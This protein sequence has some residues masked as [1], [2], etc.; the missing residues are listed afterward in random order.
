MRLAV[1]AASW[2][3][4]GLQ[5]VALALIA[6]GLKSVNK[7]SGLLIQVRQVIWNILSVMC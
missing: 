6:E 1:G 5:L 2:L 3:A 7:S 4:L